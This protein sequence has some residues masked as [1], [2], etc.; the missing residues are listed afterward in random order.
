VGCEGKE[1][2]SRGMRSRQ[3]RSRR[4]RRRELGEGEKRGKERRETRRRRNPGGDPDG[5]PANAYVVLFFFCGRKDSH[6]RR[7]DHQVTKI[8]RGMNPTT[9]SQLFAGVSARDDTVADHAAGTDGAAGPATACATE[10]GNLR[11]RPLLLRTL[12]PQ[13]LFSPMP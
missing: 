9:P 8:A 1:K 6:P 7:W 13:G 11:T 2:G 5:R 4:E 12:Q 3:R 10:G